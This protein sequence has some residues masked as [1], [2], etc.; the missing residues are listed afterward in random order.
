MNDESDWVIVLIPHPVVRSGQYLLR[1][2]DRAPRILTSAAPATWWMSGGSWC[3]AV[4]TDTPNG[5]ICREGG[6]ASNWVW[7]DLLPA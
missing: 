4:L 6:V 2:A 7:W 3:D 1:R 5:T